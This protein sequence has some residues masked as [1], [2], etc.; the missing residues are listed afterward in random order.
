MVG[1]GEVKFPAIAVVL[2][3]ITADDDDEAAIAVTAAGV[4]GFGVVPDND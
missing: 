1:L 4:E 3:A 2:A